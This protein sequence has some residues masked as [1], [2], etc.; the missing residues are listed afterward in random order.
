MATVLLDT[1]AT[2]T[3]DRAAHDFLVGRVNYERQE[4]VPY[5]EANF[6][7]DRMRELLRRLGSPHVG[8]Q[9]VHVAGTK[10]KGST[11]TMIAAILSQ[12]GRRT[13]LY[14]SPH[15]D[16]VEERFVVNGELCSA[17]ELV[18]LVEAIRPVVAQLDIEESAAGR[19]G[20]TY[21]EVTTA[22]ALLH[23]ARCNVDATVLEV[24]LGGRLDSTNVCQ[25]LLSVITSISFDHMEQLGDTLAEIAYEKAGIIKPGVPVVSGVT[26]DEPREV[27]RRIAAEWGCRLVDL[28]R[29]FTVDY[30]PPHHLDDG[31]QP[32]AIDFRHHSMSDGWELRGAA[33]GLVGKHQAANAAVALAAIAEL[34]RLGWE[35]SDD[36]IRRGLASARCPARVEVVS[37][38]PTVVVDA[39]HNVAAVDALLRAL[40]ECFAARRRVLVFATTKGKD[41]RG[42]LE[43]LVPRLDE[44]ILTRYR[45][46]PRGVPADELFEAAS[47]HAG[48]R[49]RVAATSEDAWIAARSLAGH[50][51]LVCVTGSFFIA[52]E[53]RSLAVAGNQPV[54]VV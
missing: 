45:N 52:A 46:N 42:M 20:P 47:A 41:Y 21:F 5:R 22:M 43:R 31:P 39:A 4:V 26:V 51:A 8:Q 24:G 38:H 48:G 23:F 2:P 37:R 18:A 19:H 49:I 54:G 17:G 10:G 28:E 16:R 29:D 12:S 25:P 44:V 6:R 32:G 40:D 1:P 14:T 35:I 9:I 27:I 7:L 33:L 30:R 36:A 13:A 3:A 11:A 50:D 53:V 15:L 34:R